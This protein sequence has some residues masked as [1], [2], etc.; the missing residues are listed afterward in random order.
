MEVVDRLNYL[1]TISPIVIT[2]FFL[3]LSIASVNK[4]KELYFHFVVYSLIFVSLFNAIE[5]RLAKYFN[6]YD[7]YRPDKRYCAGTNIGMPSGHAQFYGFLAGFFPITTP[8]AILGSYSRVYIG[9][10]SVLQVIVGFTIG[11]LISR[12]LRSHD[13]FLEK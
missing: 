7:L 5:K 8:F 4:R 2:V 13:G 9:C 6:V 1:F 3:Y 10:H 12:Y 11:Y